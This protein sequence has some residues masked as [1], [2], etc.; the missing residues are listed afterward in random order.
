MCPSDA[1]LA[2]EGK[3]DRMVLM[4]SKGPHFLFELQAQD[5]FILELTANLKFG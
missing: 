3:E 2:S 4:V 5:I 1:V